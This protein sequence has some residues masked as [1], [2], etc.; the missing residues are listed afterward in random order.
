[1]KIVSEQDKYVRF[2]TPI[3][4]CLFKLLMQ[5][6]VIDTRATATHLREN[7]TNLDSYMSTVS[8]NIEKFNQYVKVNVEGL[9]ARGERTDDLMIN[10]FKAYLV[11]SDAEFVRYMKTKRDLYDNGEDISYKQL[12]TMVLN[13][14]KILVKA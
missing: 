8:S 7:L 4:G 1:M 10:L 2:D 5:K 11:A 14:C 13:K 12:M 9:K 6:A 3:G